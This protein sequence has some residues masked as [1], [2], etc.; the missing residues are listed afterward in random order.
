MYDRTSVTV[1]DSGLPLSPAAASH[2]MNCFRESRCQARVL[3]LRPSARA[4]IRYCVT[5]SISAS[6]PPVGVKGGR[7]ERLVYQRAVAGPVYR[8]G[9][10]PPWE[11]EV[12]TVWYPRQDS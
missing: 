9:I 1:Q 6:I 11:A 4:A 3:G 12:T 5:R 7:S 10:P 8:I 2:A